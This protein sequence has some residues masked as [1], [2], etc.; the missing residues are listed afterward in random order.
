MDDVRRLLEG[1]FHGVDR[2]AASAWSEPETARVTAVGDVELGGALL[3]QRLTE[4]RAGG[5]FE[6]V[7]AFMVDRESGDVLLYGFD[8][9][10][11]PPE[12]AARG[13]FEGDRLVLLRATERGQ[14]RTVFAPTPAGFD[15]SKEFRP[16]ADAPWQP[17]VAGTLTRE[18]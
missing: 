8:T 14:S 16:A 2:V 12:P 7:H 13:R 17:V 10:G 11:Y 5:T 18:G 9:F 3:I 1:R 6:A 15:W 4:T